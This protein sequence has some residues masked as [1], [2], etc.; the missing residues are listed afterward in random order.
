LLAAGLGTRLRNETKDKPKALVEVKGKPLLFHAINKLMAEG[1][2]G[3][4]INVHHYADQ[5]IQYV[6]QHNFGIPIMISDER[7]QLLDTGGA[8]KHA[9]RFFA[10]NDEPVIIY[11][12]DILCHLN[13]T[14]P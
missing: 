7:E 6:S 9:S 10:G 4:V 5:I 14:D 3:V 12:V 13:L 2:D 8:L 11:N 1:V